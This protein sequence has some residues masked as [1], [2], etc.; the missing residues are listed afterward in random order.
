MKISRRWPYIGLLW[1]TALQKSRLGFGSFYTKCHKGKV[2]IKDKLILE[3]KSRTCC[4]V[5]SWVRCRVQTAL[6]LVGNTDISHDTL[7]LSSPVIRVENISKTVCPACGL[8]LLCC[9]VHALYYCY[10]HHFFFFVFTFF[11]FHPCAFFLFV[12]LC[13]TKSKMSQNTWIKKTESWEFCSFSKGVW[14]QRYSLTLLSALI[15]D[16]THSDSPVFWSQAQQPIYTKVHGNG[17]L[18]QVTSQHERVFM[19]LI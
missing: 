12:L 16:L 5:T 15:L 10:S 7:S 4:N 9:Y 3:A 19:G 13:W 14:E 2:L 18:A 8:H 17:D 11:F 1:K 6:R